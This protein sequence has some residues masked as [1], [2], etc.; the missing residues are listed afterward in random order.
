M[1][2]RIWLLV[3]SGIALAAGCAVQPPSGSVRGGKVAIA[4]TD[5]GFQPATVTLP[6]NLAVTLVVTR[7]TDQT[8]A[9]E[10]VFADEGIHRELPLNQPVEIALASHAKGEMRYTCGMG[11]VTGTILIR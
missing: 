9:K 1:S 5:R 8:C 3:L 7:E 2:W 4:V 6:R 10:I 11:M